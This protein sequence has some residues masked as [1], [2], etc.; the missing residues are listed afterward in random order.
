MMHKT[1]LPDK[2]NL[3]GVGVSS[4]DY[5]EVSDAV[6]AYAMDNRPAIV[7]ALPVHG[8][9]TASMDKVLQSQINSFEMVV[10]D[11]QPVRWALNFLYGLQLKERVYGP[12]LMLRLCQK[13]AEKGISVYFYGS[14]PHVVDALCK[15]IQTQYPKLHIAGSES[16]PFRTLTEEEDR[17]VVKK[18][19]SSG[20][21]I[22]FLGLGCPKQDRFAYTHRKHLKGVMI[23]TGAAFD[24][25]SGNKKMAPSWMQKR[26]LEWLYRLCQEPRRLGTR[27]LFTNT[28]FVCKLL[29]QAFKIKR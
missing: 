6:I 25:H 5:Q 11:G 24:F 23:C 1:T 3:L 27:Y 9:V 17:E 13:A 21:G 7:T 15:N 14:H 4:T 2:Y 28:L 19:N 16:P 29:V 26:G 18:I 8:I 20:A 10:P 22:V 12:E